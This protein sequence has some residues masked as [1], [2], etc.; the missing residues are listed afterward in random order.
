MLHSTRGYHGEDAAATAVYS[1]GLQLTELFE[2]N[3]SLTRSDWAEV[4]EANAADS[5]RVRAVYE[6]AAVLLSGVA[7]VGAH[8]AVKEEKGGL[9][10]AVA[11]EKAM[12]VDAGLGVVEQADA[13]YIGDGK[14]QFTLGFIEE[15][16]ERQDGSCRTSSVE[17]KLTC[18]RPR[19]WLASM[20][21]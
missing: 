4:V 11:G 7:G 13:S 14:L 2:F 5:P 8:L 10:A 20:P 6:R 1:Q 12:A 18:R 9:Q 3:S 15:V 16:A 21:R 19:W 17:P